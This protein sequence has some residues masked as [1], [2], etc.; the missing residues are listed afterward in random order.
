[1]VCHERWWCDDMWYAGHSESN[2]SY[3]SLWKRQQ[4]QRAQWYYLMEQIL[5]YKMVFFRSPHQWLCGFPSDEQDPPCH[6]S[7]GDTPSLLAGFTRTTH[8]LNRADTHWLV[9]VNAWRGWWMSINVICFAW[10][11]SPRPLLYLHLHVRRRVVSVP[12]LLSVTL[13]QNLTGYWS[14]LPDHQHPPPTS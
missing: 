2:S 8:L 14:L 3:L 10:S 12:L 6:T 4:I 1:M 7:T 5:S 13:Q 11:S 9:S